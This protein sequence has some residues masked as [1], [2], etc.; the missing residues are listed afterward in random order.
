MPLSRADRIILNKLCR[1]YNI[2]FID[3]LP[4]QNRPAGLAAVFSSIDNIKNITYHSYRNTSNGLNAV[5]AVLRHAELKTRTHRLVEAARDCV[6]RIEETWRFDCETLVLQRL[7]HDA[8]CLRCRQRVRRSDIEDILARAGFVHGR[9]SDPQEEA[10]WCSCSLTTQPNEVNMRIGLERTFIGRA[11]ELVNH[12]PSLAKQLRRKLHPDRVYGLR[13]TRHIADLLQTASP[14]NSHPVQ[15]LLAR[16]PHS[17]D[18]KPLLFPFLVVEAKGSKASDDWHSICLQTAFPIYTFL[19]VQQGLRAKAGQHS[20]RRPSAPLVWFI[21]SRGEDWRVY[22]AY[23]GLARRGSLAAQSTNV[24]RV[25]V[26]CITNLD[27]AL[28]LLL[29]VEYLSDWARDAYRPA[30][31]RDL[32]S[33]ATPGI[34]PDPDLAPSNGHHVGDAPFWTLRCSPLTIPAVSIAAA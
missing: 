18:G 31:L 34:K 25:W 26:G 19:N 14:E 4:V 22:L 3:E 9:L 11:S 15:D 33:V 28:Q 23:Q 10:G 7:T 17:S 5:A 6:A 27:S 13:E 8:T 20:S 12:P 30:V 24:V 21:M 1:Q 32:E 29:I 2:V 16:Q